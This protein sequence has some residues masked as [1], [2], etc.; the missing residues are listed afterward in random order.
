MSSDSSKDPFYRNLFQRV[1]YDKSKK[2][3]KKNLSQYLEMPI[4]QFVLYPWYL[5]VASFILLVFNIGLS[6]CIY[7]SYTG[8]K[9]E[10]YVSII[11]VIFYYISFA[12]IYAGKIEYLIINRKKGL[13]FK[14]KINIFCSKVETG[15]RFDDV[16]Y[17]E[18]VLKG[19]TKGADDFRK[20]FVRI[21]LKQRSVKPIEFGYTWYLDKAILK[22][23]ICVAM[24]KGIVITKVNENNVKDESEY[25]SY[26]Y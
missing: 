22:Y 18:I 8:T 9:Y 13:V 5:W 6:F 17:I 23:Q 12:L 14:R 15:V 26:V 1:I 4:H 21:N 24:I 19:A 11:N 16:D 20:Y 3:I 10:K 25:R 7:I 2:N